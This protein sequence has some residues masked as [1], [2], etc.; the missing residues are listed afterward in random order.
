VKLQEHQAVAHW[1]DEDDTHLVNSFGEVFEA[2]G[3]AERG[4]ATICRC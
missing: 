2:N 1:G 3:G 4:R